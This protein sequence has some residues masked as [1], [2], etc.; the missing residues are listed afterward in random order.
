MDGQYSWKRTDEREISITDLLR[1]ICRKWKQ[2]VI[3]AL[4]C[5]LILGGYGWIR[6]KDSQAVPDILEDTE[7]TEEEEQAVAD[8]VRLENE[9]RALEM[10]LEHSVLMQMDPYHKSRVVMLYSIDQAKRQKLQAV[11][12]SYLN[13]ILN[14]G[15]ADAL[16]AFDSWQME[17]NY[18][19]ELISAY[20]KT[21]E[22]PYQIVLDSAEYQDM[23][24]ESLF[25]VEITGRDLKEAKKM[26]ADMQSV[27]EKYSEHVKAVT[28]SH[29]LSLVNSVESVTAD[30]GLQL[31]QHDK[32]ALLSSN[33][34]S[35]KTVTDAFS[36]EQMAAYEEAA[37]VENTKKQ[38]ELE[39]ENAGEN[40]SGRNSGIV[41][42]YIFLGLAGGI[43]LYCCM[44]SCWYIFRDTVKSTEEMK[45]IYTFPVY[46]EIC[47]EDRKGKNGKA[48]SQAAQV[49]SRIR[50][51]CQKQG[52]TRLCAASD[53]SF[54]VSEKECLESI[55]E[56]MKN[57]KI[58]MTVIENAVTKTALWDEITETGNVL[59]VCRN[60]TTTHRM[61]DEEMNFYMEN[62]I[63]VAGAVTFSVDG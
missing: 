48:V 18:M 34:N 17:K 28:G 39:E 35:L 32:K 2:A 3:C 50:L 10:Y 61:I 58:E 23:L 9:T 20:Q 57:W 22:S 63:A 19:A 55:A 62:G 43:F 52:I 54:S 45:R 33:R 53:F 47:L 24:S 25:Y 46:G 36:K 26:A 4:I 1:G 59:L 5:T 41:L 37:G 30:S 16:K 29:R 14:G 13:Y 8:A 12:E 27:L 21:Y 44:F 11:T 40:I 42:K 7:L 56:Q 60:G 49:L 51:S 38:I 31:Q 6:G 15:A